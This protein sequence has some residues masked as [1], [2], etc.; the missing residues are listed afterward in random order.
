MRELITLWERIL[1]TSPSEKQFV[2]W[3]ESHTADVVRHGILRAAAKNQQ[4]GGTM[5]QDYKI[6]FASKVMLT[7]TNQ[8][9]QNAANKERLREE[10]EGKV[11]A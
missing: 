3:T 6:R 4:M 7:A 9:E 11:V 10:F 1:G 8:R 5:S 2:I